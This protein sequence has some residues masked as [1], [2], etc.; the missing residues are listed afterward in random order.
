MFAQARPQSRDD[1]ARMIT[2]VIYEA[3]FSIRSNHRQEQI[4]ISIGATVEIEVRRKNAD[5]RPARAVEIDRAANHRRSCIENSPPQS[6]AN[7]QNVR[8]AGLVF[9]FVEESP[10]LRLN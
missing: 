3:L 9:R 2:A 5:D 4:V 1:S 8:G 7:H 6:I 10:D